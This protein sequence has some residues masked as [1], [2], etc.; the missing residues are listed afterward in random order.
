M[1]LSVVQNRDK[2]KNWFKS[3]KILTE[4]QE[5]EDDVTQINEKRLLH[6]TFHSLMQNS[7]RGKSITNENEF[8]RT[9][10][11]LEKFHYI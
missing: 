7:K 3:L 5:F 10:Q 9:K 8:F 1:K 2:D 4:M 6:K 11:H